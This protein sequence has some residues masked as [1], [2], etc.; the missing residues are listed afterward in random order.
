MARNTYLE[1]LELVKCDLDHRDAAVLASVLP[2]NGTLRVLNL[3]NNKITNE[4][5][6]AI[7]TALRQNRGV[8]ELNLLGQPHAFGEPCLQGFIDLFDFNVTLT[9]IIWRLDSR[10][11]GSRSKPAVVFFLLKAPFSPLPST[12]SSFETTPSRSGLQRTRA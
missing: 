8:T 1:R 5:A 9:K 12:S 11:V 6:S 2:A 4:G 10:K 3:Q 7:A